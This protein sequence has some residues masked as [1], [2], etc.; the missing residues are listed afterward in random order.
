M[1][2]DV[3]VLRC[4]LKRVSSFSALKILPLSVVL[5]FG[6][7]ASVQGFRFAK[8]T[9]FACPRVDIVCV[10]FYSPRIKRDLVAFV[11]EKMSNVNY[12]SFSS[13]NFYSSLRERFISVSKVIITKRLPRGLCVKIEGVRPVMIVNHDLVLANDRAVYSQENFSHYSGL[14]SLPRIFMPTI[15]AGM[16]I[17][18]W[19]NDSL[20]Q[21]VATFDKDFECIYMNPSNIRLV[22]RSPHLFSLVIANENVLA[23]PKRIDALDGVVYDAARRG[24]CSLKV[25]ETKRRSIQLDIRFKRRVIVKLIDHAKRRGNV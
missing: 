14:A 1:K 9:F 2:I 3:R 19:V 4:F 18:P 7:Y 10:D 15:H 22:P 6:A 16:K 12:L 24:L 17:M 5:I 8:N 25:L 21:L 13:A 11:R 23:N 20:H